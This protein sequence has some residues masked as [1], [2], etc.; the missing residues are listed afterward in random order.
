MRKPKPPTK[1]KLAEIQ[2]IR[3]FIERVGVRYASDKPWAA[4]DIYLRFMRDELADMM[5]ENAPTNN[6]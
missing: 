2:A 1:R 5:K 4:V 6:K 3:S